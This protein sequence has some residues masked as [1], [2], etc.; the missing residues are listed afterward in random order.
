MIAQHL[1]ERKRNRRPRN[2]RKRKTE[3]S[4]EAKETEEAEKGEETG[5]ISKLGGDLFT[6][7]RNGIPIGYQRRS[8]FRDRIFISLVKS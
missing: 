8:I 2:R 6:N 4:E 5:I 3:E 1:P 7:Y